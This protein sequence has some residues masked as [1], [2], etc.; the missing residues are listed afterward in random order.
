MKSIAFIKTRKSFEDRVAILPEQI[1]NISAHEIIIEENYATHIGI[2]DEEYEKNGAT[3]KKFAEAITADIL[4]DPKIGDGDYIHLLPANRILFGY[5]HAV[6]HKELTDLLLKNNHVCYAW[7][8]MNKQGEHLF[9]E[10]NVLAGYASVMHASTLYKRRFTG[11]KAAILGRG[12]TAIGAYDALLKLGST[13]DI[14]TRVTESLLTKRLNK[15]DIIVIAVLWDIQ[16]KDYVISKEDLPIMKKNALII[17]V[18]CDIDGAVETSMPTTLESPMRKI[19]GIY[20][21][22]LSNSPTIYSIDASKSFGEV[23]PEY[24]NDLVQG[25]SNN[26]LDD[27]LILNQGKICDSRITK[28]QERE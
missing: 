14:Y 22:S 17:D 25:N 7:E 15:Y 24:L 5:F 1:K 28:Y 19:D 13:V 10:N 26:V 23:I 6:Q 18:S 11:L 2:A 27:A 12:N 4:V 16:R 8:D 9:H 21:Y 3:I 20:H